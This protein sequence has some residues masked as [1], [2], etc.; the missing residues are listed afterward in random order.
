[1]CQ[2]DGRKNNSDDGNPFAYLFTPVLI[3]IINIIECWDFFSF[4][5]LGLTR[6]DYRTYS[7]TNQARRARLSSIPHLHTLCLILP[8]VHTTWGYSTF[9]RC[10]KLFPL[11]RQSRASSDQSKPRARSANPASQF[12]VHINSQHIRLGCSKIKELLTPGFQTSQS[13]I[14]F[15]K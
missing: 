3:N 2:L 11:N 8:F 12:I 13:I 5:W 10:S 6:I 1:M 7:R 15:G 14:K 9:R 4:F